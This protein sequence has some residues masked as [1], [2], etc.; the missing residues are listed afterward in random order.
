MSA[1]K[2]PPERRDSDPVGDAAERL[3]EIVGAAERAAAAVIDDAEKQAQQRIDEAQERADRIVADRLRAI[4][5]ELDPPAAAEETEPPRLRTVESAPE[6]DE[7]EQSG[8]RRRSGEAGARLL[9][10]QMAVSGASRKEIEKRLRTGA[11]MEDPTPLL[12][13]IL[14][15]EE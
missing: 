6:Q 13:A 2:L 4:A 10:T 5:D 11:G 7:P 12:D 1:R 15:P 14:G 3:A 9:A 8:S